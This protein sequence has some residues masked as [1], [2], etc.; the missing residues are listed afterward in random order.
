[1]SI[2][3]TWGRLRPP[4]IRNST[5][6]SRMPESELPSWMM[7]FIFWISSSVKSDEEMMASRDLIQLMLPR[8]VLIS[9]L[10]AR[11]RNGWA[12]GQVGSTLVEK[13]LWMRASADSN[14]SSVRS[15]K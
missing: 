14:D 2:I 8:S 4:I 10:W 12:S 13:R 9:P 3:M 11:V 6:L 5:T 1:M 15:G 7:G